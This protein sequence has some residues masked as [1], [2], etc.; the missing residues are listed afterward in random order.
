MIDGGKQT[1]GENRKAEVKANID[2]A[3]LLY[4]NDEWREAVLI[5]RNPEKT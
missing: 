5:F 4:L 1:C 3:F 2:F